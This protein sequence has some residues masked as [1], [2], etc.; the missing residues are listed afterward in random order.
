[1]T[2]RRGKVSLHGGCTS[3]TDRTTVLN[4]VRKYVTRLWTGQPNYGFQQRYIFFSLPPFPDHFLG[5]NQ[6]SVQL[7]QMALSRGVKRPQSVTG[8][9]FETKIMTVV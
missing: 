6:P 2:V 9:I 5:P 3:V 7:I 8:R 4:F 1:M